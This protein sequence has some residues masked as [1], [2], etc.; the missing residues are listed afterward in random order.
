MKKTMVILMATSLFAAAVPAMA[1]DHG[2]MN[3]Q[4]QGAHSAK[5]CDMLLKDCGQGADSIQQR[6]QKLQTAI[7]NKNDAYTVEQL[8]KL[9]QQLK[10][11]E[12]TLTNLEHGGA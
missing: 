7:K 5:E 3:N 10:E 2:S 1:M 8:K 6:I 9:Q 4:Q 12:K 11:A